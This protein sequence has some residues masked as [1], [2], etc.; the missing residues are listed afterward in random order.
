[1]C[2]YLP[3]QQQQQQQQNTSLAFSIYP[4]LRVKER[5]HVHQQHQKPTTRVEHFR[6]RFSFSHLAIYMLI[7]YACV[8]FAV[9]IATHT[10]T[11]RWVIRIYI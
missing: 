5:E 6:N 1:M 9:H 2:V 4:P 3:E 10:H 8:G 11:A 7:Y